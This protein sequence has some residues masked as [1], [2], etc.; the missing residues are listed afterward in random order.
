MT[1][2]HHHSHQCWGK[3]K[4]FKC[5][6]LIVT[7]KLKKKTSLSKSTY[8]RSFKQSSTPKTTDLKKHGCT[9]SPSSICS[10][11]DITRTKIPTS[12]K[13]K[14]KE[15]AKQLQVAS[16]SFF[17]L[18]CCQHPQDPGDTSVHWNQRQAPRTSLIC[19]HIS[20]SLCFVAF[21]C[22]SLSPPP[23]HTRAYTYTCS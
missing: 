6:D 22:L 4:T 2:Q 1:V 23:T 20:L 11:K 12:L 9:F 10:C 16:T 3:K 19:S 21:V 8:T 18:L 14:K 17:L 7:L 5:L 13:K 15:K